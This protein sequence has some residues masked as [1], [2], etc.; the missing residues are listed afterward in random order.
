MDGQMDQTLEL[1][2]PV[3]HGWLVDSESNSR[4]AKVGVWLKLT[5]NF[6]SSKDVLANHCRMDCASVTICH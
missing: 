1:S 3:G 6:F 4:R 2:N 5:M